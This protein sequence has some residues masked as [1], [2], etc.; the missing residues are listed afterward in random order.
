MHPGRRRLAGENY[1]R[2]TADP[3]PTFRDEHQWNSLAEVDLPDNF[4]GI[5]DGQP[6]F[7]I[8]TGEAGPGYREIHAVVVEGEPVCRV[9]VVDYAPGG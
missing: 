7:R 8:V 9:A 6:Y 5:G 1:Q 4:V 3:A 2:Y